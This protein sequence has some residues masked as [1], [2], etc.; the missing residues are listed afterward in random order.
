MIALR[1]TGRAGPA[2][3]AP[4]GHRMMIEPL[5]RLPRAED[6]CGECPACRSDCAD[7]VPCMRRPA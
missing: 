2:Q 6:R 5:R 7:I 1:I 3:P 4:R